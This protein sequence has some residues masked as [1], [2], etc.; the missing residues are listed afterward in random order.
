MPTGAHN[1]AARFPLVPPVRRRRS[2]G[3]APKIPRFLPA[4]FFA[5][6][7]FSGCVVFH[8]PVDEALNGPGLPATSAAQVACT[9][10]LSCPD[11][12]EVTID[13]RSPAVASRNRIGPDGRIDLGALGRPRV[14]G[15]TVAEAA[16]TVG[17]LAGVP[18]DRVLVQVADYE[19]QKVYVF[20]QVHGVQRAIP[21]RG[22]ET[23]LDLLRRIGGITPGAEPQAV[24]VIRP[25]VA[26]GARPEIFA[27]DLRAIVLQHDNRTNVRLEPFDQIYIGETPRASYAKCIP[28]FFR[29]VYEAVCGMH[30][31]SHTDA[32]P[33]PTH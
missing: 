14:E 9:Y 32:E 15:E 19:S 1:L 21:F 28:P 27:V 23:V 10:R 31:S 7:F 22:Q 6:F 18:A 3:F 12:V 30:R 11:T 25:H 4:P 29:P 20:G 13:G 26:S 5:L 16:A 24:Y 33:P 17:R 8:P 2:P